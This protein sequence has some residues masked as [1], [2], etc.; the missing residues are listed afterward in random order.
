MDMR[1]LVGRWGPE[2]NSV[3]VVARALENERSVGYS[4][5]WVIARVGGMYRVAK[6]PGARVDKT[7]RV[8]MKMKMDDGRGQ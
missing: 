1:E 8:M 3:N 7:R 4:L 2:E 6:A 5:S